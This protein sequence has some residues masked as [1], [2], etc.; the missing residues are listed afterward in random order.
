MEIKLKSTIIKLALATSLEKSLIKM[1]SLLFILGCIAGCG[2]ENGANTSTNTS[3]TAT[4][5]T[6][7]GTNNIDGYKSF[8]FGMSPSQVVKLPECSAQFNQ[9]VD[10]VKAHQN[11]NRGNNEEVVNALKDY[12]AKLEKLDDSIIS[13]WFS[14]GFSEEYMAVVPGDWAGTLTGSCS[15]DFMGELQKVYLM[16]QNNKLVSIEIAAGAFNN[17]KFRALHNAL[18][19]KYG[20]TI[21]PTS[22][23][24]DS[25]N[26]SAKARLSAT[27]AADQ[28]ELMVGHNWM[29]IAYRDASLAA[30]ARK[31]A[32]KGQIKQGDL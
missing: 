15:V 5:V 17:E 14:N 28:V 11:P 6:N 32:T 27:Y 10:D 7:T 2:K 12:Q 21:F 24:I 1:L 30:S 13:N 9:F 31:E 3:A 22:E 29:R 8:K 18:T 19:Q 16:F 25:F 20:S 4:V 23:Q 26:N